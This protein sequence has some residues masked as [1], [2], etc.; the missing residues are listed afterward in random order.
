MSKKQ[1]SPN[2]KFQ[3]VREAL[4]EGKTPR[5]IANQYGI[6]PN[7]V[8]MWKKEFLERGMEVLAQD[9]TMQ[10][11]ER[12]LTEHSEPRTRM[13]ARTIAVFADALSC[14]QSERSAPDRAWEERA[15]P[16][17]RFVLPRSARPSAQ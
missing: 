12:R 16:R 14:R 5:Q 10:P 1:Y 4:G 15:P 11:Y 8:R 17:S 6:H 9:V 7:S 2:L 3:V 13:V